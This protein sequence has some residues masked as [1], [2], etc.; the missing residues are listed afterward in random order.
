[1]VM[2]IAEYFGATILIALVL[3]GVLGLLMQES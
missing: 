2:T 1:M 3:C